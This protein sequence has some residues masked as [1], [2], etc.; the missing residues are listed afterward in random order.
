MSIWADLL[1]AAGLVWPARLSPDWECEGGGD[2]LT[3]TVIGSHLTYDY[4]LV[5]MSEANPSKDRDILDILTT[6]NTSRQ[7]TSN[8]PL[9][10]LLAV[11]GLLSS[12]RS[13]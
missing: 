8:Y 4:H 7:T 6:F 11:G 13:S 2:C 5:H 1:A 3:H 10:I 12:W 9:E